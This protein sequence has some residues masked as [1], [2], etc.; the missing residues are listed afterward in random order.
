ML[1][2][3]LSA[4]ATVENS[5]ISKE[6]L[7]NIG[8]S[9]REMAEVARCREKSSYWEREAQHTFATRR[10]HSGTAPPSRLAAAGP[11]TARVAG[12]GRAVAGRG[13][14]SLLAGGRLADP[15]APRRASLVGR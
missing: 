9:H 5:S 7:P 3:P 1:L 2:E 13:R 10:N 15:S 8:P 14:R 12:E 6:I 4:R 11:A